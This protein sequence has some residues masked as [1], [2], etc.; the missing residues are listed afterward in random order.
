MEEVQ[1]VDW[2]EVDGLVAI[3]PERVEFDE[4]FA[5]TNQFHLQIDDDPVI[6]GT[7]VHL[8]WDPNFCQWQLCFERGVRVVDKKWK[9]LFTD[10]TRPIERITLFADKSTPALQLRGCRLVTVTPL[11]NAASDTAEVLLERAVFA[12]KELVEV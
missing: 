8:T 9:F 4:E 7:R 1:K 6:S 2:G 11:A 3:L 5:R 10:V 12:A